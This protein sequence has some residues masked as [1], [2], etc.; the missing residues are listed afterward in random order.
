M[1]FTTIAAT[2]LIAATA[3]SVST[4]DA[5]Q[6][7]NYVCKY[8]N[9]V[10]S[11]LKDEAYRRLRSLYTVTD[12]NINCTKFNQKWCDDEGGEEEP[13]YRRRLYQKAPKATCLNDSTNT[14]AAATSSPV[15]VSSTIANAMAGAQAAM[16]GAM[17]DVPY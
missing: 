13:D 12:C 7:Y 17:S 4:T 10:P 2:I 14:A 8:G 11:C 6:K 3:A 9:G 1:K 15:D 5:Y 16:S